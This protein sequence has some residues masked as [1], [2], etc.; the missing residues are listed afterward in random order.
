M[1]R[2]GLI[3]IHDVKNTASRHGYFFRIAYFDCEMT[4]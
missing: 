4:F 1:I 2:V 3:V